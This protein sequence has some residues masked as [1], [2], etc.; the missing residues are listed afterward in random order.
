MVQVDT[1]ERLL[2]N[3]QLL[4]VSILIANELGNIIA[5]SMA[6]PFFLSYLGKRGEWIAIIVMTI[7]I[8]FF[9]DILP[10]S[11]SIRNSEKVS[12]WIAS[13]MH[14]CVLALSPL[15]WIINLLVNSL[16]SLLKIKWDPMENIYMES[17]IKDLVDL[18]HQEGSLEKTERDLIHRVFRLSDTK[19]SMIMTPRKDIFMLPLEMSLEKILSQVKESHYSRIPIYSGDKDNIVGI[20]NA[21]DLLIF[22]KVNSSQKFNLLKIIRKPLFIPPNKRIDDLLRELQHKKIHI[23]IVLDKDRRV[24]GLVTME[25]ILE[26]L[27]GEIYDEYDR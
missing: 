12:L 27:F 24:K 9:C 14:K 17:E 21:K 18:G 5:S 23:A 19:V 25:D 3:P 10:K 16:I 26:E 6:T 13:P 8:I 20:L 2:E 1:I 7:L 22:L 15:R 4:L 11:F